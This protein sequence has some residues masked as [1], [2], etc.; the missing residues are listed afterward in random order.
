MNQSQ[1]KNND[2]DKFEKKKKFG[3]NEKKDKSC[4]SYRL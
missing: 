1:A 2:S 3:V 4:T